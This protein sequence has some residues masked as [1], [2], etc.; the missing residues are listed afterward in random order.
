MG[1]N[2]ARGYPVEGDCWGGGKYEKKDFAVKTIQG[3]KWASLTW[4]SCDVQIKN[5]REI[6]K[7]RGGKCSI[8]PTLLSYRTATKGS[9]TVQG[10]GGKGQFKSETY[11]RMAKVR[12]A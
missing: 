8:N 7:G 1:P 5:L 11:T 2:C 12:K 9:E 6:R 3:K 4:R 10:K